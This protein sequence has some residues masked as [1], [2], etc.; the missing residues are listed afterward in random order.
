MLKQVHFTHK[1]TVKQGFLVGKM[2]QQ[3]AFADICL[4][5]HQ[6]QRKSLNTVR[7]Q[8]PP[9]CIEQ[10]VFDHLGFV[11]AF[12]FSVHAKLHTVWTV[13]FQGKEY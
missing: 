10:I 8:Y 11:D 7:D 9:C 6:V 5:C 13:C 12:G 1:Q 2:V 4:F 3:T